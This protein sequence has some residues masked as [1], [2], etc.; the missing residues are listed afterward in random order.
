MKTRACNLINLETGQVVRAKSITAFCKAAGLVDGNDKLHITPILNEERFHHKNWCL[1]KY[2]NTYLELKDIYG[3]IYKGKLS[4]FILR[5]KV[6]PRNLWNLL[7]ER[8]V[9]ANGLMLAK[10]ELGGISPKPYKIKRYAFSTPNQKEISGNT[11]TSIHNQLRDSVSYKTLLML[12][13]GQAYQ[14]SG[15]KVKSLDI[16]QRVILK[17]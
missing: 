3:N 17:S 6:S 15:Y 12:V 11:I 14:A 13:N 16:E 5:Y 1:P 4:D 2:Y 7:K 10:T 8:K 9:I